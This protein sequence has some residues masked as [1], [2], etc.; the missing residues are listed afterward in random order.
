M[1]WLRY[2]KQ[3]YPKRICMNE[4]NYKDIYDAVVCVATRLQALP[5]TRISII[6][7]NSVT[8]AVYNLGGYASP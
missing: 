2:G 1:E 6:S 5:D 4:Y 8:M 7:D 3:H